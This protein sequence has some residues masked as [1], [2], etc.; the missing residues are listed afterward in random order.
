[1]ES[2][3]ASSN[4]PD[5]QHAPTSIVCLYAMRDEP[6][7]RELQTH[8]ILWQTK[9]HI[10]WLELSAGADVEQTLQAFV[11]EADLILLLISSSF[12]ATSLYHRVMESALAEQTKRGVLVVPILA[13][14]RLRKFAP[15]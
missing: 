4:A 8:L 12:F 10:R 3:N 13:C 2:N 7:Y 1:L 11:Q 15:E 5:E 14:Q 6:M 9:E